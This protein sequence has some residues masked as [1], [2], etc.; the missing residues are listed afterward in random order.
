M[1]DAALALQQ[2][3]ISGS[4]QTLEI[5]KETRPWPQGPESH[6]KGPAIMG[7]Q[8]FEQANGRGLGARGLRYHR[9]SALKITKATQFDDAGIK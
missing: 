4:I 5:P 3:R 1:T 9:A 7:S 8:Y 6:R 2:T